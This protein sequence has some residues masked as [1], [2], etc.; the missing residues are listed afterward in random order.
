MLAYQNVAIIY[1]VSAN[2]AANNR[3]QT[4]TARE[5]SRGGGGRAIARKVKARKEGRQKEGE[6][7]MNR[8]LFKR[9]KDLNV[10]AILRF[11]PIVTIFLCLGGSLSETGKGV[12][13][14]FNKKDKGI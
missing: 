13:N 2:I 1:V 6:R 10:I 4:V 5:D 9:G 11:N 3:D 7:H 12:E 14:F 8:R